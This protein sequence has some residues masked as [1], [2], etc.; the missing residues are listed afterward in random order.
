MKILVIDNDEVLTRKVDYFL[1]AEGHWCEQ[2]RDPVTGQEAL[3]AHY[4]DAI[5]CNISTLDDQEFELLKFLRQ[6]KL[7][8]KTVLTFTANSVVTIPKMEGLGMATLPKP[9]TLPVLH[10]QLQAILHHESLEGNEHINF[11]KLVIH[12][13]GRM[14]TMQGAPIALTRR[15]YDLL[16]HL[17][18]NKNKVISRNTLARYLSTSNAETPD[19]FSALY[20]HVKNLKKKLK[21]AGCDD[22]IETVYGIGYRLTYNLN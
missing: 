5:V 21:A 22:L 1:K 7:D 8:K 9:Y 13:P 12:I 4:Y 11:N 20:V 16:L 3:S 2:H 19:D 15:E 6:S 17:A 10:E 18:L 14:V